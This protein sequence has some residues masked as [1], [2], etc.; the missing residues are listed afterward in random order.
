[1]TCEKFQQQAN[2]ELQRLTVG[3]SKPIDCKY[4]LQKAIGSRGS[5]FI[6]KGERANS[7][8]LFQGKTC[9]ELP[10]AGN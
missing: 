2:Q 8:N 7:T 6:S 9:S 4:C 3:E 10:Q 1:M 5:G